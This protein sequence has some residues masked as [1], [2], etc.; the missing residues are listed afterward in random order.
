M[1][2]EARVREDQAAALA[3]LRRRVQRQRKTRHEPVT[4]NTLIRV[5]V[6][7]LLARGEELAGDTEDDLRA[8]LGLRRP[9][10]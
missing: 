9:E 10:D 8:S 2:K 5:A 7:L 6:D 1:R 3:E 4:D